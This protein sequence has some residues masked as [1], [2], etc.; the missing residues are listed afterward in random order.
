[1]KKP[2]DWADIVLH[3]AGALIVMAVGIAGDLAAPG[4]VWI[5][6]VFNLVNWPAREAIQYARAKKTGPWSQQKL[7]E[8]IA[9]IAVSLPLAFVPALI[10][11]AQE[12][13]L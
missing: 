1:M 12:W 7:L 2:L 4:A 5:A 11:G 9:P 6:F 8:A 3:C 10:R 13:F